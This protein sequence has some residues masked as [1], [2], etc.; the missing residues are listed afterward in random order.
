MASPHAPQT[1]ANS[2]S[3][4]RRNAIPALPRRCSGPKR[5]KVA[6]RIREPRVA[7]VARARPPSARR[8]V[9][10]RD[11]SDMQHGP[12]VAVIGL[13]CATPTLLFDD[14][15]AEVPTIAKLMENGMYG[16]L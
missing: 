9:D 1:A 14:L 15:R 7:P 13:D 8:T 3:A 10:R 16:D 12:R 2:C 11:T 5:P 6:G 4:R